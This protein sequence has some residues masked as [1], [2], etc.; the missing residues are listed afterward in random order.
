ML[1]HFGSKRKTW[2]YSYGT[3]FEYT[4]LQ[5]SMEAVLGKDWVR[6]R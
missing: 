2:K 5:S 4:S 6:E 1:G 3:N